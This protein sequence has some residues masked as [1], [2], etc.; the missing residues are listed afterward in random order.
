MLSN[1]VTDLFSINFHCFKYFSLG[2][3]Y[4]RFLSTDLDFLSFNFVV[5][6]GSYGKF[7]RRTRF[8]LFKLYSLF[9][10]FFRRQSVASSLHLSTGTVMSR[11]L[12]ISRLLAKKNT[13]YVWNTSNILKTGSGS[14]KV[15]GLKLKK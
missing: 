7:F 13:N 6:H 5:T 12:V 2:V 10:T 15:E 1:A 3:P 8:P 14:R 9:F 11:H 4:V